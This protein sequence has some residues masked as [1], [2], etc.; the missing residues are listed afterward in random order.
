MINV[1]GTQPS[2]FNPTDLFLWLLNEKC[3]EPTLEEVIPDYNPIRMF[4]GSGLRF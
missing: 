3:A 4:Y 2:G 1:S